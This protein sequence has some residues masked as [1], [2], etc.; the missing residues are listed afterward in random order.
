MKK[1]LA[2]TFFMQMGQFTV[3]PFIA[4]YLV[5]N[6]GIPESQIFL[7]YFVGG[8]FTF[9]TARRIGSWADQKGRKYVV[10]FVGFLSMIPILL[11]TNLPPLPI[12]A[13]LPVTVLFMILISG[14][15]IPAMALITS[16]VKPAQR[17]AFMSFNSTIQMTSSGLSS[18]IAGL[19]LTERNETLFN[20]PLI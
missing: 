2:T 14:R 17:G 20:Y 8:S 7:V 18:W 15:M 1:A 3:I 9:Y 4:P 12:Y 16:T 19:I 6:V 10:T 5:K 13:V 11:F